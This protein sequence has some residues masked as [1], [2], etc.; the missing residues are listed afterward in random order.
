MK[1]LNTYITEWKASN[2]TS[3]NIKITTYKHI[4]PKET[5]RCLILTVP[6]SSDHDYIVLYVYEYTY[7]KSDDYVKILDETYKKNQEGYYTRSGEA[8]H[9][10]WTLLFDQDAIKF[11]STLLK[12]NEQKMNL[13]EICASSL[14]EYNKNCYEFICKKDSYHFYENKNIQNMIDQIS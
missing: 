9:W 12:N 8:E 4:E 5:G 7:D 10:K 14:L 1:T 13:F 2:K 3:N 11:L 6:V